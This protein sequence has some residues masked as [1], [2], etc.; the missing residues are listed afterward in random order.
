MNKHHFAQLIS[1]NNVAVL[2]SKRG[3]SV[4]EKFA[5]MDQGSSKGRALEFDD[6]DRALHQA[7]LRLNNAAGKA[8]DT[9]GSPGFREKSLNASTA[10]ARNCVQ[11]CKNTI[12]HAK[13]MLSVFGEPNM[14][15][16]LELE[17]L[18]SEIDSVM[19]HPSK[20]KC[21]GHDKTL[22]DQ[23]TDFIKQVEG[24]QRVWTRPID[25]VLKL[26]ND[27]K[28]MYAKDLEANR[29]MLDWSANDV[30]KER[31]TVSAWIREMELTIFA[32]NNET[33]Q[34]EFTQHRELSSLSNLNPHNTDGT[35]SN[36]LVTAN[37]E[38]LAALSKAEMDVGI[39]T[40][41]VISAYRSYV[42][43]ARDV[44]A[45]AIHGSVNEA[46]E[47][48]NALH[49][50]ANKV[51]EI[52]LKSNSAVE[53]AASTAS[54]WDS[55]DITLSSTAISVSTARDSKIAPDNAFGDFA[56][57]LQHA[58][59]VA[60]VEASA[61][62]VGDRLKRK[63]AEADLRVARAKLRE[64]VK[65]ML[66]TPAPSENPT[67]E[68]VEKSKGEMNLENEKSMAM[69]KDVDKARE[70][71]PEAPPLRG[72]EELL[73]GTKRL[74]RIQ[75]DIERLAKLDAIAPKEHKYMQQ[76][77]RSDTAQDKYMTTK[78]RYEENQLH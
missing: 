50:A 34:V 54:R 5:F 44:F 18:G 65:T 33:N 63:H 4:G 38:L 69:R 8:L 13:K 17:F 39:N 51:D 31:N 14:K 58:R 75:R 61:A 42:Q 29:A 68:Q 49:D 20:F 12:D 67:K 62:Q 16:Q 71:I 9:M 46:Q 32:Q 59:Q 27:A 6:M 2:A 24:K 21:E 35:S 55:P 78:Q 11:A 40:V 70:E 1:R 60:D 64:S 47:A 26:W 52:V 22:Q 43:A 36:A 45:A 57:K 19:G 30:V 15:S 3:I 77:M 23:L 56:L 76:V 7:N 37:D 53:E 73:S 72:P 48:T 10:L 25:A 28:T 74:G 66:N 41:A